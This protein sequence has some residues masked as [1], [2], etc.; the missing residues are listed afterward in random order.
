MYD[1]E[2]LAELIKLDALQ[3]GN[4]ILASGNRATYYLDCRKLTL[5]GEAANLIAD[6]I[7]DAVAGD[8]PDCVGGMAIGADPISA[9][10]IVRAWQRQVALKGFIVRKEPKPHGTGKQLEGPVTPGMR[11]LIV[12]DVITTGGSSLKAI[13]YAREFGLVVDRLIAIVDRGENSST[14]FAEAGVEFQS[15]FHVNELLGSSSPATRS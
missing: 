14:V 15:L 3:F 5:E 2:R 4:F 11:A 8:L 12:E 10:V 1:R 13:D 9:A 7:L 6:G